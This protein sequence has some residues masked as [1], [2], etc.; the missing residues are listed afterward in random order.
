MQL[1]K[2]KPREVTKITISEKPLICIALI[3]TNKAKATFSKFASEA[4]QIWKT[5]QNYK[6]KDTKPNKPLP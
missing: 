2:V 5:Q 6:I 1:K 4:E 3:L